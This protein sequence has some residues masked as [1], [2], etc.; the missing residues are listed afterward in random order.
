MPQLAAE[1]PPGARL[2][3]LR[4][5]GLEHLRVRVV[6]APHADTLA[7][8][9]AVKI[10]APELI[11]NATDPTVYVRLEFLELPPI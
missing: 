7:A 10:E 11:G 3:Q 2:R 6:K 5:M 4:A 8:W 1:L 9:D